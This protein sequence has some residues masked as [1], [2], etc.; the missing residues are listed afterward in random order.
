MA[1]RSQCSSA[2]DNPLDPNYLPPHYREEYRL[3]IDALIEEDLE[4]YYKFLKKADVVDF[5][6]SPEILNIQSSIKDPQQIYNPEQQFLEL[7]GDG[8]SDTYWPLHSDLDAPG[9]DLG[10]PQLHHFIGPTEVTTLVNPPE[11]EMP[12]IKEQ[13]RRLIKNAQQVIAIVMDMF[14]DVDIFADILD[15]ARRNVA[16]YILLDKQ[17]AHHFVD[18]VSNCRVNLQNFQLL[19]V[20]TVSGITYHC[21]SGK[22]FNGQMMDRFLLTD[23]RAVLSGNYSFMW[24]FEKL[25]RCMAHLF[26]GQLVSTF[27]E[28]FRILFAQSLPLM[29][30]NAIP[31][32]ELSLSQ[33][34][35]YPS[36]R[37]LYRE[38]KKFQPLDNAQPEEWPRHSYDERM[39]IDW[40]MMPLKK[41]E[42]M[43]G[44][45]DIYSRF[46]S[47]QSRMDPSFDK[48]SSRKPMMENLALKRHSYTEDA[49]GRYS[50]PFLQQGMPE[51]E[52]QGRPSHRGQ[53]PGPVQG[54]EVDYSGYDKF[55]NQDF[56]SEDQHS[57]P[58]LPQEIE[59]LDNFDPVLNYL[60]S[61]RIA[62]FDQGSENLLPASDVPFGSSHPRRLNV[63]QPHAC[64]K[65]PTPS[66]L[67]DQ[68]QFFQEPN[69]DRKDPVVKRGLR[70]WR[71][72]SYLSAHDN[73][74]DEGLP[75]SPADLPDTF[76]EPSFPIQQTPGIHLSVP[77]IPNVREF[78]VPAIP[79]ASQIP[80]YAK[81]TA[82]E[83]P[84]KLPD[85]PIPVS[86]ETKTTPTPSE[87]SSTTEVEKIEEV[88]QK[89]PK[90]AVLR[91]EDSFRRNY[92]AALPRSS[93]LRSSLIFSSL[94]QQ[95]NSQ[96]T[97][98]ALDQQDEESDKNEP[99][100]KKLPFVSHV[101][102][103][104]RPTAREPFEWSRYMKSSTC[105]NSAT[106][107]SKPDDGNSTQ[108]DKDSPKDKTSK[109]LSEVQESLKPP[110]EEQANSSPCMP[111]SKGF[112]A[113]LP[114]TVQPEQPTK[115]LLTTPLHVD[116]SDP[117]ERLLF[118]KE[119]AAKRKAAKATE[120][121]KSKEK[122]PMKSPTE[123]K[124]NTSV[125][126][127][128]PVP[129]ETSEKMADA[130]TSERLLDKHATAED[131]GKTA[132]T[133]T[134]KP[135]SPSLDAS[136]KA[137]KQDSLVTTDLNTSQSCKQEQTKVSTD[138]EK[139]EL[140]NSQSEEALPVSAQTEVSNS[141]KS[142][143]E[144]K[145]S[146]IAVEM[147]S[148][149]VP[150][151]PAKIHHTPPNATPASVPSLAQGTDESE[152]QCLDSNTKESGLLTPSSV[153]EPPFSAMAA[154]DSKTP[155]SDTFQSETSISSPPLL[156][157]QDTGS[158]LK[159]SNP[160]GQSSSANPIVPDSGSQINP[161]PSPSSCALHSTPAETI[162]SNG[163][164]EDS[165]STQRSSTLSP[166]A[167][168]SVSP[169]PPE[170]SKLTSSETLSA[171][172]SVHA[173][174]DISPDKCAAGLES[175]TSSSQ[176][177]SKID[178]EQS[179]PSPADT[180]P[181]QSAAETSSP[182]LP[183]VTPDASQ[184][185][186]QA[187]PPS[188]LNLTGSV[189]PTP[190]ET[191]TCSSPLT[192]SVG[193]VLSPEAEKTCIAL[194][195]PSE[196]ECL[197]K[198][199]AT[200]STETPML[201]STE[202]SSPTEPTS[203]V[204]T[205][206]T[207]SSKTPESVTFEPQ[208]SELPVSAENSNLDRQN[209]VSKEPEMPD[210]DEIKTD[211]T[212][213]TN[214]V[215]KTTTQESACN[216]QTNEQVGQ[217]NCSEQPEITSDEAVPASPQSKQPKS[218]QSRYQSS[219]ANVLSSS[220]LRDDTKILLEQ[221]SANSQSR[222]E[223]AKESPVTDDEKEDEADKNAKREKERGIRSL[224]RGQPKTSQEREML[225][226]RIQSMRKERKVYSRFEMAP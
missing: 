112:E 40:R 205:E 135:V 218:G 208:P 170:P 143:E 133:E 191:V 38:P 108:D 141:E 30:E 32:G 24:S 78:K 115:S 225:L 201:P 9:L 86:T 200:N 203:K 155:N 72:S 185:E 128:E 55:W 215:N 171:A 179:T 35:Q 153:E 23:C 61:T 121:E 198:Q 197:P 149:S 120:A 173:E 10:W 180:P 122:P 209:E 80:N 53:Q 166:N 93:R 132:S 87:S 182:V 111:E 140:M 99:G 89:E 214:K 181:K 81:T 176:S 192:E 31:M 154:L 102:G 131:S 82:R 18:M 36:D 19:R 145:L 2:G 11:P 211:D 67:T 163:T 47:Q 43:H 95:H 117:D 152:S 1:H 33:K 161:S 91:R 64:Q 15:A 29:I 27:D 20:R 184:S 84:K 199:I 8:S 63:G 222:I 169:S 116:M 12:S 206:P 159:S 202:T 54:K 46:T 134:C 88:E 56:Y 71:I 59:P 219:T 76:E 16:V 221:I 193:S 60:S 190:I 3:A 175:N 165:S 103:Q 42:S 147:S 74:G 5:L 92:N 52:T 130:S 162:S 123:L 119:L 45:A 98:T 114:K 136:D 194:H 196:T 39:D 204:P 195:S 96:D 158:E 187:T 188:E 183:D 28:E 58:G 41:Q 186:R 69:V 223:A 148:P 226:E 224:N 34:R 172:D 44:P 101:L 168:E 79:R 125:K 62:D 126:K 25:H 107:P 21:R 178:S 90:T 146:N 217:N 4:G 57:E 50:Y 118:F 109:D 6:S 220:N 216:E 104:R 157:E 51:P 22:S 127:D 66:N 75:S 110:A 100:Q 129:K 151:T 70:N 210:P 164:Q 68:K 124:N 48:G 85:E 17:N 37:T 94:E 212:E 138:S 77:K 105:D 150:P 49:H 7:G 189:S 113:E 65:S 144:P 142:L 14:T 213:A 156:P 207:L 97:K 139:I 137:N 177:S 174:S 106:D 160:S 26:L 13:A 73:P 83:Q 167:Q